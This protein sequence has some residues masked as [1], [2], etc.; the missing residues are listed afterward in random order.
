MFDEAAAGALSARYAA[1]WAEAPPAF[2]PSDPGETE[3][4]LEKATTEDFATNDAAARRFSEGWQEAAPH[5]APRRVWYRFVFVKPGEHD[6]TAW[7]GVTF[8]NGR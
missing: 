4:E 8:V 1:L 2:G 3:V 5:L 6:G 7:E